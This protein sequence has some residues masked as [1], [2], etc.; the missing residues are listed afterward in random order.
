M[1][2]HFLDRFSVSYALSDYETAVLWV[3][4]SISVESEVGLGDVSET[5]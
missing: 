3:L 2:V 4:D 5:V 1:L